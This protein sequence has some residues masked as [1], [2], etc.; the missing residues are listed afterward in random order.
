MKLVGATDWFVRMPFVLEGVVSGIVAAGLASG[1][2]A[3][4]YNPF[5]VL[6]RRSILFF[7]F[8]YDAAYL[9]IIVVI[10]FA[11]GVLLG[12]F[13]SLLGVRRFLAI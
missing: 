13:G 1:V 3:L 12:A 2:V 5:V 8:T 4:L 10:L 11:G 6:M 7:P 9:G